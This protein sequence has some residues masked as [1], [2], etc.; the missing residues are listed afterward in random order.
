MRVRAIAPNAAAPEE[1]L[2]L[3]SDT[4][5]IEVGFHLDHAVVFEATDEHWSR[6]LFKFG[7]NA[8]LKVSIAA[9]GED[10]STL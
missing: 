5:R 6:G 2:S 4:G 7:A 1:K 9:T 10:L 3:V 8:E